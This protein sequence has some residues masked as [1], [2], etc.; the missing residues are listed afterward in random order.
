MVCAEE[1]EVDIAASAA[2][3]YFWFRWRSCGGK[4]RGVVGSYGADEE[5]GVHGE[6]GRVSV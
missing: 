1:G 5:G 3:F 6:L 2:G 4:Y